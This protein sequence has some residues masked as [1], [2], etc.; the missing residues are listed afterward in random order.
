MTAAQADFD[1]RLEQ[2]ACV[3]FA[4]EER[5]LSLT[6]GDGTGS[7]FYVAGQ[8]DTAKVTCVCVGGVNIDADRFSAW[9]LQ[10]WAASIT[11]HLRAEREQ[12][13]AEMREAA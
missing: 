12:A 4:E 10:D 3:E 6:V 5:E 1:L 9:Q 8:G 11:K 7:V 13:V 2:A